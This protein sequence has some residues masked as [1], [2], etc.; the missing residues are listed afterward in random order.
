LFLRFQKLA[1]AG[2]ESQ[3]AGRFVVFML[4]DDAAL[5]AGLACK[6]GRQGAIGSPFYI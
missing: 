2:F 6:V 1:F 5:F 4:L 3:G